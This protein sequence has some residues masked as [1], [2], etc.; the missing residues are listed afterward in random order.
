MK[1]QVEALQA[2]VVEGADGAISARFA[3]ERNRASGQEL[4]LDEEQMHAEL[5]REGKLRELAAWGK[6]DVYT[7]RKKCQVSKKAA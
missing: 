4:S 3:D 7:Q 1:P 2:S 5:V 6:F